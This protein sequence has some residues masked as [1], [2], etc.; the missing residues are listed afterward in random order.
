MQRSVRPQWWNETTHDGVALRALLQKR[1]IGAIFRYLKHREFSWAGIGSL[2]GMQPGRVREIANEQ[3]VVTDYRVLERISAGLQIPRHYMGLGFDQPA[4]G[5]R[6]TAPASTDFGSAVIDSRELLGVVARITVGSIPADVDRFLPPPSATAI[7]ERLTTDDIAA[8][9]EITALHRRMDAVTGGGACLQSALGY[10]AWATQ[11]LY[12]ASTSDDLSTELQ[13]T[14]ADLHNLIGWLAHDLDHHA[15]ARQHL[16]QSLVLA[17]RTDALPLLANGLYRLGRVSLH[18]DQPDEALHMFGLGQLA[19]QEAGCHASVAILHANI[20]W[21]YARL[22][23]DTLVVDSLGRAAAERAQA[24]IATT[25]LW[26][27]FALAGADAHGISAVAYTNL[28][29]HK[30][31]RRYAE[32]A[33]DAAYT[34]VKLRA[35]DE[36]RSYTFD[37]ISVAVAGVLTGNLSAAGQY[38]VTATSLVEQGMRSAR[39]LDRLHDLWGLAAP[40]EEQSPEIAEFGSR[41]QRLLTHR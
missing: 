33:S 12:V 40:H 7:P 6:T 10:S 3:R 9:R 31:H 2:T 23:R 26:A 41:L 39:V 18:L 38:G 24:D 28:A 8:V 16:V 14:L 20:A 35:P 37:A 15:L 11:L 25:P 5:R 4:A 21:A 27:R 22:G 34:A 32:Q 19:A 36:R 1:D 29:R 30:Q 13:K 17:R